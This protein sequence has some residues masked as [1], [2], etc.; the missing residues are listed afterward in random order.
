M[1]APLS[2]AVSVVLNEWRQAIDAAGGPLPDRDAKIF[3][4]RLLQ[5][6]PT[7]DYE[8]LPR[9]LT[10]LFTYLLVTFPTERATL[11]AMLQSLLDH[12]ELQFCDCTS[13]PQCT[14]ICPH[15]LWIFGNGLVPNCNKAAYHLSVSNHFT[16]SQLKQPRGSRTERRC[17]TPQNFPARNA[18]Q[19][20]D[21]H[22]ALQNIEHGGHRYVPCYAC[23]RPDLHRGL[24]SN[25]QLNNRPR[26]NRKC[27][28]CQGH[29]DREQPEPEAYRLHF[30]AQER[31]EQAREEPRGAI[32]CPCTGDDHM[33]HVL[34]DAC[35]LACPG[36]HCAAAHCSCLCPLRGL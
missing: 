36:E 17:T 29:A 14:D 26:T 13:C 34:C 5:L 22:R 9:I 25:S 23:N 7:L 27:L 33:S 3:V 31:E 10:D 35:V 6:N 4:T 18:P 12:S 30:E 1:D 24:F 11:G 16:A 8:A 20:P 32:T 2:P 28:S 15:P 19:R 21:H